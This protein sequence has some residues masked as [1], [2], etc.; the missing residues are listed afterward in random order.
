MITRIS[1]QLSL[2]RAML[3]MRELTNA[4]KQNP[5]SIILFDEVE[6][7]HPKILDMFLQILDDGRL[8]SGRGETV[9]FSES[10]IIFTSNLGVYEQ[11]PDGTKRQI[12]RTKK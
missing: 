5:F 1:G 10:L 12:C 6:K 9:Y 7:A 4:I 11:M 8:T 3:A 2:L